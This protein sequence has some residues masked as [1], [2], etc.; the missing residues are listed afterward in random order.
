MLFS[1]YT[2]NASMMICSEIENSIINTT[3]NVNETTLNIHNDEICGFE[4][5]KVSTSSEAIHQIYFLFHLRYF[6]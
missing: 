2:H 1:N 5:I 3:D 4:H 6:S